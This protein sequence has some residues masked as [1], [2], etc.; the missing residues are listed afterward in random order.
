MLMLLSTAFMN[1]LLT[2]TN[3]EGVVVERSITPE[4]ATWNNIIMTVRESWFMIVA[5]IA[6]LLMS[7]YNRR[8]DEEE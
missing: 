4:L 8:L 1:G 3:Q 7:E 5:L 2:G 6:Y